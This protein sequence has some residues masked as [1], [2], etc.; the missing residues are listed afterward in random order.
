L[1]KLI[2]SGFFYILPIAIIF[3]AAEL[4]TGVRYPIFRDEFYYLDCANHLSFGYVDHPGFSIFILFIWKAVFGSSLLSIRVLPALI[5][6]VIIILTARITEE[7]GGSKTAQILS[8]VAVTCVPTFMV[9]GGFYSMNSFDVLFWAVLF[10]ILIKIINTGNGKLWLWF[11]VFTGIALM[12]K[13][14]ILYLGAGIAAAM[15]FTKERYWFRNKFFWLGGIIALLI[16]SPYMIWNIQNDY[17]TLEFI[18][19]AT[20]F[21]NANIPLFEFSK[22]QIMQINP[23]N[24]FI[25][26]TG[27]AVLF[28]NP[29][30]KKYRL[31]GLAYIFV[32]IILVLQKSKPYYLAA[33]YPVLISAGAAAISSFFERKKLKFI[34]Y[35]YAILLIAFT[36]YVSPLFIPVLPPDELISF[37]DKIGYRPN[38]G[39]RSKSAGFPQY[40]ADRFGWE[41]MTKEFVRVYNTLSDE[42]KKK[43]IIV[44]NN[45]G[46]A[47]A[48]NY[49][50]QKYG[51]PGVYC[52]HNNQWIWGNERGFENIET[53]LILG[54]KREDHF[55]TCE[56]VTEAGKISN[57]Y[58]MPFENNLSIFIGRHIKPNINLKEVW[59][60]EKIYI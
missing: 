19:N 11:G 60:S 3:I 23:L 36:S 32:F 50:S 53:I 37:M 46:E 2:P 14:S 41:E 25:W 40:F 15:I 18:Q 9:M 16:F 54:G 1:V 10:Y 20:K 12:N 59:K 27:L 58:A 13:I 39:E 31:A 38:T 35:V 4:I 34:P 6:S 7:M 52:P 21:K 47:G 57:P 56:E 33:A 45:Y 49:Y 28:F 24:F 8:A 26:I 42:E 17:A 30:L 29:S 51:L 5:G 48:L 43:T 22:E 55:N 44:V